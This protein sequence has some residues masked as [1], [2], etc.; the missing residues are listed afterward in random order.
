M[1]FKRHATDHT[2]GSAT[3]GLEVRLGYKRGSLR[4]AATYER[5]DGGEKPLIGRPCRCVG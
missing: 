3:N 4:C 5:I 1:N 2:N